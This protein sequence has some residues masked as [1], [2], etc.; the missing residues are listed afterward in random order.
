MVNLLQ[1]W[2]EQYG[3]D[4]PAVVLQVTGGGS[5]V[6]LAALAEGTADIA[7]ASREMRAEER[8]LIRARHGTEPREFVVALDAVAIYVHRG[9][10][11]A[12]ITL[13]QLAEIFADD[14]RLR[15][16]ADLDV[17]H[18]GCPA[19]EIIRIGR[20]NNSGT[21]SYFRDVVLGP[22]REYRLG[23]IDQT[24]SKDVVALISRTPCAIGY[25]GVAFA[26]PDV[27]VLPIAIRSLETPVEPDEASVLQHRYPLARPL[28]LYTGSQA[29]AAIDAFVSWIRGRDGQR[30]VRE[31]GE[32]PILD[33]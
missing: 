29:T 4:R 30:V 6:G 26:T 31:L 22:S 18:P 28:Y 15:R 13:D 10:P 33:R 12:A 2:A 25:S 17:R 16:W 9:N 5:G 27:K 8:S 24:G 7:A 11:L 23:S 20:Q 14:G 3:A 1:A 19:D 32:V 21:F